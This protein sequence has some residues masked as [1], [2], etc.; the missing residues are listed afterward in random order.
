MLLVV[1][2]NL[3]IDRVIRVADFAVGKVQRSDDVVMQPGGKGSNLARVYRQLGG[4]VAL[5]GF[6][7]R[8]NPGWVT[9]PLEA[10]GV[11][12]SAVEAYDRETRTC[13][14][15]RDA[16]GRHPTV[17]NEETPEVFP[18]AALEL[19]RRFELLLAEA[20]T[21][22]VT[23]SLSRGLPEDFYST[24]LRPS[25]VRGARTAVDASGGPLRR[26][27]EVR[28]DIVKPNL[29]EFE[30]W[31]GP[32]SGSLDQ[33]CQKMRDLVERPRFLVVTLGERGALLMHRNEIWHATPP[34]IEDANPIGAGD[35]FLAGFLHALDQDL[36]HELA[37]ARGVAAA[38]AD[39]RSLRSG[40]VDA[41][42]VDRLTGHVQIA[43]L[44]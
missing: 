15:I 44:G 24:L 19:I 17:I 29:E 42:D 8:W 12:V 28:P 1:C 41:D 38:V 6:V 4:E 32:C 3:A 36:P 33:V 14:V 10:L 18:G 34:V 35:S 26:A 13:T 40:F 23:G 9:E 37:F 39:T 16:S 22:A 30:S 5:L 2:P 7:G 11:R 21:V 27:I 31:V 20:T 43:H 25:Q